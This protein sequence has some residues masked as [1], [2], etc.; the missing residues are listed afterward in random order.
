M[1]SENIKQVK[2]CALQALLEKCRAWDDDF[3]LVFN[4]L[5]GET[6]T[7]VKALSNLMKAT[8]YALIYEEDLKQ[9]ESLENRLFEA[10]SLWKAIDWNQ[11]EQ[12]RRG[13]TWFVANKGRFES[14]NIRS[15]ET[16]TK[17]I[18][19][20]DLQ[21]FRELVVESMLLFMH[22]ERSSYS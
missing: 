7:D 18:A 14:I 9:A 16:S 20:A 2:I 8:L 1:Q 11:F 12:H 21:K 13:H 22:R 6:V 17:Y 10:T 15:D 3:V 5:P 19:N 4:Q